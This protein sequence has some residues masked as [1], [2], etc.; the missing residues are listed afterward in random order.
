M[1]SRQSN[2]ATAIQRGGN[3]KD[4]S[5][6]IR[7]VF[8][9]FSLLINSKESQVEVS[10][11]YWSPFAFPAAVFTLQPLPFLL[12]QFTY[13]HGAFRDT[14]GIS[15]LQFIPFSP[16]RVL[17]HLLQIAFSQHRCSFCRSRLNRT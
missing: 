1:E 14:K 5:F 13:W 16:P 8:S 7:D 12:F 10:L 3:E 6:V 9:S 15:F 11:G 4:S 17:L 2:K